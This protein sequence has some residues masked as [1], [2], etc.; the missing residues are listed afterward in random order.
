MSCCFRGKS[1]PGCT[2]ITHVTKYRCTYV[3]RC[4]VQDAQS[5]SSVYALHTHVKRTNEYGTDF[6][7]QCHVKLFLANVNN[8]WLR[9]FAAPS[10]TI[11]TGF[12]F[13]ILY[14]PHP[15]CAWEGYVYLN[16]ACRFRHCNFPL[17]FVRCVVV[18]FVKCTLML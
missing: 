9:G 16:V 10:T 14:T 6:T 18:G 12:R 3:P 17:L 15:I 13:Y 8:S 11:T 5:C 1:S 7:F 4:V 2:F